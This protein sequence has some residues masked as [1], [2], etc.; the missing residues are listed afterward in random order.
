MSIESAEVQYDGSVN[1]IDRVEEVLSSN[2]WVF[3]R[4][5]E[6]EL[7]VQ[8][9]GSA[10][11]Y[12]LFFIWDE[13]MNALQLCCQLESSVSPINL[14]AARKAVLAINEILWIGHFDLPKMNNTPCFRHA[15]LLRGADRTT[16]LEQIDDLVRMALMQCERYQPLFHMLAQDHTFDADSLSLAMTDAIGHS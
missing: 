12:K 14:D 9:L 6:D 8:V 2:R 11:E 4:V 1:P 15:C 13:D 7:M 16:S 3:N 10:C 5:N